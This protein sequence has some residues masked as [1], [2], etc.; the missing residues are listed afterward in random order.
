MTKEQQYAVH[1]MIANLVAHI[2]YKETTKAFDKLRGHIRKGLLK[3]EKNQP[4][5]YREA[6][7][8][9]EKAYAITQEEVGAEGIQVSLTL[10]IFALYTLLDGESHQ[11]VW[12][13]DK[14]IQR[15]SE[16]F[17]DKHMTREGEINAH[18][19]TDI[20]EKAMGIKRPSKLAV[21]RAK[22][23]KQ[24]DVNINV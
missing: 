11:N 6:M 21:M 8:I 10:T 13:G 22:I 16:S 5:L 3:F 2:D 20:F 15:A 7:D 9:G 23:E 19:L 18:K 17:K 14:V 4:D 24:C 12:Y 1:L